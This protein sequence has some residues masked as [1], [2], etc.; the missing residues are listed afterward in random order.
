MNVLP[1]D[2]SLGYRRPANGPERTVRSL[3]ILLY[4]SWAIDSEPG[5]RHCCCRSANRHSRPRGFQNLEYTRRF[6]ALVLTQFESMFLKILITIIFL[7]LAQ[8]GKSIF[9]P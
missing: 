2:A 9:D 7:T 8:A 1:T 3:A 6:P 5:T 4:A